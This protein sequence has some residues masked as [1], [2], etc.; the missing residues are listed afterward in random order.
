MKGIWPRFHPGS[1]GRVESRVPVSAPDPNA[2]AKRLVTEIIEPVRE[3][4]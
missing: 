2:V 3:L 4:R 1:L